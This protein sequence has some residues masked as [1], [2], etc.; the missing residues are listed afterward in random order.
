MWLAAAVKVEVSDCKKHQLLRSTTNT[1]H[2]SL[3]QKLLQQ[4]QGSIWVLCNKLGAMYFRRA[5]RHI[6]LLSTLSSCVVR[7]VLLQNRWS[8]ASIASGYETLICK[9][10]KKISLTWMSRLTKDESHLTK[11]PS[12]ITSRLVRALE[13]AHGHLD[14]FFLDT[15]QKKMIFIASW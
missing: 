3:L 9:L 4:S 12:R 2:E 5:Y 13:H 15:K 7:L 8:K 14:V 11:N 1:E 10:G 6:N